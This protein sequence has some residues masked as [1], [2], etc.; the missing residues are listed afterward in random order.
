MPALG[1]NP[2][3]T[4][5]TTDLEPPATTPVVSGPSQASSSPAAGRGGGSVVRGGAIGLALALTFVLGVGVGRFGAPLLGAS[6]GAT[7]DPSAPS[8]DAFAL[9]GEA[10]RILHEEYVGADELDD[11]A[12][13]YGAIE[14]LTDAVGDTGH[15]SFLTPEE[16][17]DRAED[18]SGSYVGIGV[19]IDATEDGRPLVVAVF[20]GSPAETAGIKTGDILVA[21]DGEPT[22]GA[23]LDDVASWI[24]GEAG[25]LVTVRV[26]AGV[27]GPER[28]LEM[29]RAEVEVEAV[30]WALYPGTKTAVLRLEQFSHG[31]ADD[32]KAALRD[33]REAGADRI[34]LDLR[35]NPGGYVNEAVGVASQFLSSGIV[36]VQRDASGEETEYD[37]S[38][39]GAATDLPLV[40]L[41]DAATASSAEIVSG[42]LQ[43]ASR[44]ELIGV[45]TYGTGTVLGEFP[46]ADGSALRVGTTEWLTPSGRRIWHEGIEPDLVVERPDDVR[47]LLPDDFRNLTAAQAN[48]RIDPQL[49]RALGVVAEAMPPA[50]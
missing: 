39:D 47:P 31:S 1:P 11:T 35:G 38:P 26:Q 42:A 44:A 29:A 32:I 46:L 41:I 3:P 43:D 6:D 45:K 13:A 19:R 27:D 9:I 12:L 20:R 24:R 33:I 49:E 15:T 22:A 28:D 17:Q 2:I 4:E 21:V 36:Y 40:V 48:S 37:V 23:D 50:S 7:P 18:L 25:S 10:W 8:G 5:P 16:R 34:V 14:G 30:S